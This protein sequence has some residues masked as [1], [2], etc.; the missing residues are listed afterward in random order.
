MP[1]VSGTVADASGN[2][3]AWS[4]SWTVQSAAPLKIIGMSA[5]ASEWSSRLAEVG[6]GGVRARRIFA[7]MTSSGQDQ[8]S[9]IQSAV[10]A[11]MMPVVS[12]KEPSGDVAGVIAGTYDTWLANIKAYLAGLGVPVCA[13]FHHEPRGD[14]TATQFQQASQRF[15]DRVK[16]P[17]VKVGPLLNGWLLTGTTANKTEFPTYANASLLAGWDFMGIDTYQSGTEASPGN[18]YPG[19]RIDPLVTYLQGQGVGTKP[20]L[21]GEYNGFTA[22]AIAASGEVFLSRP[23]MWVACM[24]NSVVSG[25]KGVVLAGDRLAAFQTTKADARA[26]Q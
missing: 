1:T 11:G 19:D 6:P 21:V 13:V 23:T 22:D 25:G 18:I 3:A 15:L 8:S 16:A 5:P 2:T 26:Q 7:D 12:Y 20:I 24:W 9:L 14:M 17:N 4:A 10:A